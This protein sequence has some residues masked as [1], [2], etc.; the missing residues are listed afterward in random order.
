MTNRKSTTGFPTSYSNF[1]RIKFAIYTKFL[2][3]KT[4]SGKFVL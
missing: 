1:N 2:Y 4:S 3:V